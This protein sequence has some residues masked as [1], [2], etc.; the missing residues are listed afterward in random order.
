MIRSLSK[1]MAPRSLFLSYSRKLHNMGALC[2]RRDPLLDAPDLV[3]VIFQ[4][5]M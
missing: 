4:A 5:D 3:A 1:N 2:G